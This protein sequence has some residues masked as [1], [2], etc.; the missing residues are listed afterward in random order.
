MSTHAATRLA[1]SLWVACVALL[2]LSLLLDFLLRDDIFSRASI[3][4]RITHISQVRSLILAVFTGVVSLVNPTIGAIIVSRLP[5]NPIGWILCGVGL[6]YQ[7]RHFSLAYADYALATN[8]G[9]PW[10]ESLAWFSTW[11]GFAGLILAGIFL[12]LL[13]PDGRLLSRRWRIVAWA[14]ISGATLAALADGFYPGLLA[15]HGYAENPLEAM[16]F[17]AAG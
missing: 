16:G 10:G 12:M 17:L 7:L 14:A 5:R 4:T 6:L 8:L 11:I 13:F 2:V 1:W 3:G 15:T 9:L